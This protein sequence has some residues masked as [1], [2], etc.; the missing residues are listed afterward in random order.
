MRSKFLQTTLLTVILM[1]NAYAQHPWLIKDINPNG[2]ANRPVGDAGS[3]GDPKN[4]YA[5]GWGY[6]LTANGVAFFTSND[7][8]HGSELWRSDGTSAGTFMLADITPGAGSTVFGGFYEA[9]NLLYFTVYSKNDGTDGSASLWRTDGTVAGTFVVMTPAGGHGILAVNAYELN[10]GM[11]NLA[12]MLGSNYYFIVADT[13]APVA[14]NGG[15][16]KPV[17]DRIYKTDGTVAGTSVYYDA[18]ELFGWGTAGATNDYGS[19]NRIIGMGGKLYIFGINNTTANAYIQQSNGGPSQYVLSVGDGTSAPTILYAPGG[20]YGAY[21]SQLVNVNDNYLL[22]LGQ[23]GANGSPTNLYRLKPGETTPVTLQSGYAVSLFTNIMG[24]GES[25]NSSYYA[26]GSLYFYST[27]GILSATNGETAGTFTI[28]GFSGAG[29]GQYTGILNNKMTFYANDDKLYSWDGAS[30]ASYQIVSDSLTGRHISRVL[31]IGNR[32]WYLTGYGS[33]CI[34]TSD[35]AGTNCFSI[36]P[37]NFLYRGSVVNNSYIDY[38][39]S[40]DGSFSSGEEPHILKTTFKLF[41]AAVSN[42][43]NT[44][45]NWVPA[46]VPTAT[47]DVVIPA[48]KAASVPVIG[49]NAICKNLTMAHA[50]LII[51][52]GANLDINGYVA[53][54]LGTIKGA[55]SLTLK[56]TAVKIYGSPSAYPFNTSLFDVANVNINGADV[57]F[58]QPNQTIN[59]AVNFQTP[60]KI[61]AP[62]TT[63]TFSKKP[64]ITGYSSTSYVITGNNNSVNYT[65]AGSATTADSLFTVPIGTSATSY[66]PITFTYKFDA[67]SFNVILA[68]SVNR[69]GNGTGLITSGILNKKWFVYAPVGGNAGVQLSW[70]NTADQLTGFNPNSCYISNYSSQ[71]STGK[72]GAATLSNSLYTTPKQNVTSLGNISFIV[73]SDVNL[74]PALSGLA[75]STGT[76]SPAFGTTNYNYTTALNNAISTITLTPTAAGTTSTIKVNGITVTSGSASA[77]IALN[78]G[79]NVITTIVSSADGKTTLTYTVNVT[80][81][82]L[83]PPVIAYTAPQ[84]Y[85]AGTAITALLPAN[86]GGAVP[87]TAYAQASTFAGSGKAGSTNGNGSGASFSFPDGMVADASGNIYVSDANG[88]LIRKITPAGDVSTFAGS[89]IAGSTNGNG[90][91]ASFGAPEGLAIDASGNLYV[92]DESNNLIRKITPAGDVSTFAGSGTLASINGTGNGASFYYPRG[93]ATDA[94]GNVYVSEDGEMIRKITPG[95]VVSTLAG[96]GAVGAANNTGTAASFNHPWGVATDASGNVYVADTYNSLIRKITPGGAVTTFAGSGVTGHADGNGVAATFNYPAALAT[97]AL[98][99]I[100]VADLSNNLIRK[101]TPGGVVSTLAGSGASGSANGVGN[102]ATF[103][104]LYCITADAFGNIYAGDAVNNLIRKITATGY[105]I[106]PALPAGLSFDATTGTISGTPAAA[107]PATTYTVTAYNLAGSSSATVNIKVNAS[108]NASLSGLKISSGTLSPT[109]AGGTTAYTATVGSGVNSITLTPTTS[110]AAASTTVNGNPV[111]SGAASGAIALNVGA[112]VINTVV[113]AG[114]GVTKITYTVTVTRAASTNAKLLSL[115]TSAGALSPAFNNTV[116]SYT[117]AVANSV[118]T[119]TLTPATVDPTA[120]VTVSGTA[121]TSGTTSGNIALNVG[122]N[123]ITIVV[124]AQDGVTKMTY[125]ITVTRAA[126][127]DA[128]LSN[129]AISPGTIKPAFTSTN[130]AY[131]VAVG[132][133]ITSVTVTP[134][135]NEPNATIKIGGKAVLSGTASAPIALAVGANTIATVITAQNGVTTKNY[136]I[137]VT[138]APSN[139]AKLAGLT[140]SSGA[141]SPAFSNTVTSY[142]RAASNATTSITFKPVAVDKNA[143]ITVNGA[144]TASGT[145]SASQPLAVGSNTETI[146]VTAQ[147]GVTSITYTVTVNRA[148]GP[149]TLNT[150]YEPVSVTSPEEKPNLNDDIIL[151]HQGLSPNG[152]G[153]NDFLQIDGILAHPDNKLTIMNRS[154]Q[155]VFESKGYDNSTKVFDGHSNKT[156]AMQLPGTYFYSLDYVVKGEMKHQTG[157]IVLKY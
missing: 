37:C 12:T 114:D 121:V 28:S 52:T 152:D 7:V 105:A 22:M 19:I 91:A 17:H 68:D 13:L 24:G 88:H 61:S 11:S 108:N 33:N 123:V 143:T 47:D 89:G 40:I 15:T 29:A 156:G 92:A 131:S 151:V 154:G 96:S 44:A 137:T 20:Y 139:N 134:T 49:A 3:F 106:A 135:T 64:F 55:G 32:A 66:T 102:L 153:I 97:D 72:L 21:P 145:S 95:G 46:G 149:L 73:S 157:F 31:Q 23:F 18:G 127:T 112:N 100:Y 48:L 5:D 36:Y 38:A 42:D 2:T 81:L 65:G 136:K 45:G 80:R 119:I 1:G 4:A 117:R 125:T 144:V 70:N 84:P 53:K 129:L 132:N 8:I 94:S 146:K 118:A 85:T 148:T 62:Y 116:T 56:N 16:Y 41:T 128:T 82:A 101:I 69:G 79:N 110:D 83:A 58:A 109:F 75:I 107:S 142:T 133:G 26:S 35:L 60:N 150:V 27:N 140:S 86:T 93:V 6:T 76:L 120:T 63:L 98:G 141:L 104:G 103:S 87:S 122:A 14:F 124:T 77:A 34:Q 138:R 147:D 126:S 90:A 25:S 54:Y 9:G 10:N 57:S 155:L 59:S 67:G 111:L 130:V 51:N 30:A 113:T 115:T 50:A 43:W 71:W 78:V 74:S 99:N 39:S